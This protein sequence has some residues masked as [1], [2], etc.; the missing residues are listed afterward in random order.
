MLPV[1]KGERRRVSTRGLA[2]SCEQEG[3]P[4]VSWKGFQ[5]CAGTLNLVAERR[6]QL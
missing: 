3:V 6:F 5:L 2:S 4:V 1:K